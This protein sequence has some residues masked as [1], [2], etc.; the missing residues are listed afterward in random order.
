MKQ[1]IIF[2]FSLIACDFNL[3]SQ[4]LVPNGDFEDTIRCPFGVSEIESV[5]DWYSCGP[6]P[7]YFN[8][9]SDSLLGTPRNFKGFQWPSS[10]KGYCGLYTNLEHDVRE[11]IGVKLSQ[12]LNAG[13]KYYVQFKASL[14]DVSNYAHN[15]LGILFST[16]ANLNSTNPFIATN[17]AHIHSDSI[18]T[19]YENWIR[20]SGSFVADSNY[21]YIMIGNF[22]K[23]SDIERRQSNSPLAKGLNDY[24]AYYFID[25][26]CV[27]IDSNTCFSSVGISKLRSPIQLTINPN[28]SNGHFILS[29]PSFEILD[30]SV[31]DLKG[32]KVN[33]N[34]ISRS[35]NQ[36]EIQMNYVLNGIYILK[37][38]LINEEVKYLKLS[39]FN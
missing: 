14:S 15:G 34:V 18:I 10:K 28:P 12:P 21:Q 37:V 38:T 3:N 9:C 22:F 39:V 2:L 8:S 5:R 20:V 26:V 32:S 27:S 7:D 31:F 11:V 1:V 29:S 24:N 13:I 6:T 17:F 33:T 25:D 19:N 30:Y 23:N 4:N 36:M 35:T 16:R